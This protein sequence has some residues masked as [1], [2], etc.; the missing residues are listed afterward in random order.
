MA[1]P[2]HLAA[3]GPRVQPMPQPTALRVAPGTRLEV[4]EVVVRSIARRRLIDATRRF[5][6]VLSAPRRC[7]KESDRLMEL[8]L[9]LA[10]HLAPPHRR[11]AWLLRLPLQSSC[12]QA[13]GRG[14]SHQAVVSPLVPKM[15]LAQLQHQSWAC[16]R[17][18]RQRH[19]CRSSLSPPPCIPAARAADRQYDHL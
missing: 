4:A 15:P 14:V 1:D 13:H 5:V 8:S 19:P 6:H 9:P 18:R 2:P 16:R 12:Q 11:K 7:R 3:A 17:R 10:L